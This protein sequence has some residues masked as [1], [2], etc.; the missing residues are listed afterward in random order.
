MIH[1]PNLAASGPSPALDSIKYL[2]TRSK[3]NQKAQLLTESN[4]P[5]E[6]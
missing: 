2:H 5:Q 3:K 1:M 4:H 6:R